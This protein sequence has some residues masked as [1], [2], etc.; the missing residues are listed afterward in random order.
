[1]EVSYILKIIKEFLLNIVLWVKS[2]WKNHDETEINIEYS[3]KGNKQEY[4]GFRYNKRSI[5]NSDDKET[6][7]VEYK[8]KN[9]KY[10]NLKYIFKKYTIILSVMALIVTLFSSLFIFG[11][12]FY[13]EFEPIFTSSF[14]ETKSFILLCNSND[15]LNKIYLEFCTFENFFDLNLSIVLLGLSLSLL[16]AGIGFIDLKKDIINLFLPF[17]VVLS[18]IFIGVF[19]FI[20]IIFFRVLSTETI[21]ELMNKRM[22]EEFKISEYTSNTYELIEQ[23]Q[24]QFFSW[25]QAIKKENNNIKEEIEKFNQSFDSNITGIVLNSEPTQIKYSYPKNCCFY[26]NDGECVLPN[27]EIKIANN[28]V[29]G[30]YLLKG[31]FFDIPPIFRL[32]SWNDDIKLGEMAIRLKVIKDNKI[33][34]LDVYNQTECWD[35]RIPHNESIEIQYDIKINSQ[36]NDTSFFISFPIYW[37]IDFY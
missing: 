9:S 2:K 35:I 31:A 32:V 19:I 10:I 22:V 28:G 17:L 1:M 37:Y 33:L 26:Y 4:I 29:K 13:I 8:K 27:K 30:Q 25:D 3:K 12:Y 23:I 5:E 14:Y 6:L 24:E 20:T 36:F 7:I 15:F 18:F 16:S 11:S 21:E 34:Y